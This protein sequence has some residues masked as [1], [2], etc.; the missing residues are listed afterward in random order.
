LAAVDWQRWIGNGIR[1]DTKL[2][3]R[4]DEVDVAVRGKSE[5]VR[6]RVRERERLR[7]SDEGRGG[8]GAGVKRNVRLA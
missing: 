4:D 3:I 2:G 1:S 5:R 6:V 8:A 7:E